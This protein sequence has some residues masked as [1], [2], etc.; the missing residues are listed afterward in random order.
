MRRVLVAAVL[1]GL[2]FW[3]AAGAFGQKG[4]SGFSGGS[5]GGSSSV[6]SSGGSSSVRSSGFSGGGKSSGGVSGKTT[7]G[8][9]GGS[10][11]GSALPSRTTKTTTPDAG[12]TPVSV[13]K[14]PVTDKPFDSIAGAD[15]KKATSRANYEKSQAPKPS[16]RAPDGQERKVDPKDKRVESVRSVSREKWVDRPSRETVFY[17]SYAS[18]PVVVY[19]DVYHPMWN[20]WLLSQSLDTL[21]LWTYHHQHAMDAARLRA[22]Y[23][24]NAELEARVRA[25][26]ARGVV[27]DP[28]YVPPGVDPD[29][30]YDGGFV[31]AAVNPRPR[32]EDEYE[33]DDGVD[34]GKFWGGVWFLVRWTFYLACGAAVVYGVFYLLFRHKF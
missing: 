32:E 28:S 18:R 19:H 15:G 29:L 24:Q 9:S 11:G 33:Y 6:R 20:Y 31:D 27:R 10:S 5:S 1:F 26:E 3:F 25:M 17:S 2:G 4:R 30:P 23:A 13:S 8:F 12:R 7:S 22:L 34:W 21:T 16:Y 14:K